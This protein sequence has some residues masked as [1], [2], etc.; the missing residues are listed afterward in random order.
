MEIDYDGYNPIKPTH[1]LFAR[2]NAPPLSD[3]TPTCISTGS[4]LDMLDESNDMPGSWVEKL[5]EHYASK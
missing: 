4:M 3:V 2:L 5:E 1:G